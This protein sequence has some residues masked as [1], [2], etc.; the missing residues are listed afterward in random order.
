MTNKPNNLLINV[1]TLNDSVTIHLGKRFTFLD[2]SDF[3]DAYKTL[4]NKQQIKQVIVDLVNLEYIDSTALGTLLVLREKTQAINAS[5]VLT[6]P[7][8]VVLKA[9]NAVHFERLFS[10]Q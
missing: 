2:Q 3:E 6:N 9:L 4:L 10:I 5:L 8:I 1:V 7:K